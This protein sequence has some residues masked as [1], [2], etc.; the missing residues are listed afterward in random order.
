MLIN[1]RKI[2]RIVA[3]GCS[4]TYGDELADRQTE[5]WLAQLAQLCNVEYVNLA[6]CGMGNEHISRT[7]IDYFALNPTHMTD[8]FVIPCFTKFSRIEFPHQNPYGKPWATLPMSIIEPEFT[9]LFLER[10]YNSNWE[11]YYTR[12]LRIIIGL[13]HTFKAW[14]VPYLMCEGVS[15]ND[16]WQRKQTETVVALKNQIDKSTWFHFFT[17]NIDTLTDPKDRAPRGH[18]TA[19]AYGDFSALLHQHLIN[20]YKAEI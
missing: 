7:L 9:Q 13:Q 16:H 15:G 14:D 2:N 18:P 3:S 19:K 6:Y 10:F 4:F 12:Y 5:T 11:Y 1:D 8:S 17:N 20:N